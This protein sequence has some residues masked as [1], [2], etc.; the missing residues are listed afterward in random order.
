[1]GRLDALIAKLGGGRLP[2]TP[3]PAV[4]QHRSDPSHPTEPRHGPGGAFPGPARLGSPAR[5]ARKHAAATAVEALAGA[6]PLVV[7]LGEV[8]W[9]GST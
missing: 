5:R 1:M 7:E 3:E 8:R 4:M 9:R 6:L 2:F